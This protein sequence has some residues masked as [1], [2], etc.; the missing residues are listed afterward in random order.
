[1]TRRLSAALALAAAL[2]GCG[3]DLGPSEATG[4]YALRTDSPVAWE[5][6]SVRVT[7]LADTLRLLGDGDGLRSSVEQLDFASPALRDTTVASLRTYRYEVDGGRIEV[8]FVCPPTALCSPPPH[9]WGSV[10]RDGLDLRAL[11]DPALR[12]RYERVGG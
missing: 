6:P 5:N 2:S 1:M 8:D 7:I 10:T 12:L 4:T 11:V 9:M 3:L